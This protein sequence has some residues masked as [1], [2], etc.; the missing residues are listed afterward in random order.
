MTD[1][2]SDDQTKA[3][4]E[5]VVNVRHVVSRPMSWQDGAKRQG[6]KE[7]ALALEEDNPNAPKPPPSNEYIRRMSQLRR[8]HK[9]DQRTV[10]NY[11]SDIKV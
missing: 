2:T 4:A 5:G 7:A 6:G 9:V 1:K 11:M 8:R 10:P 3:P